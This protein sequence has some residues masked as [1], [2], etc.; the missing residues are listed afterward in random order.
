MS[1]VRFLGDRHMRN[2]AKPISMYKIIHTG[3]NTT[4]G[5]L[6]QGL[7]SVAYHVEI[8]LTVNTEDPNPDNKG[9]ARDTTNFTTSMIF[10]LASAVAPYLV[11]L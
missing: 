5:G 10:I 2:N 4:F 9:T 1:R 8:E 6:N 7:F 3:A 11:F